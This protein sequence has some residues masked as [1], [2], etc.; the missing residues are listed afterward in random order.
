[1]SM[2]ILEKLLAVLPTRDE[3]IT[4]ADRYFCEAHQQAYQQAREGL[5]N[6]LKQWEDLQ[7]GQS[8]AL[9]DASNAGDTGMSYVYVKGVGAED[10]RN[11]FERLPAQFIERLVGYFNSTYHVEIDD[12]PVKEFLLPKMRNRYES[13]AEEQE[14]YHMKMQALSLRY[15][16]VLEQIFLQLGS[17]TFAERALD[18]LKEKCHAAAWNSNKGEAEFLLRND[19]LQLTS[20]ACSCDNWFHPPRWELPNATK[21]ILRGIAHFETGVFGQYPESMSDVFGYHTQYNL[22]VFFDCKKVQQLKLFKNGRVDIK[23]ASKEYGEQFV[24]EYLGTAC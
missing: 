10:F 1:M 15:E 22:H 11:A 9:H 8:E 18:E 16:D 19:T 2:E 4:D 12:V 21:A 23:F 13:T 17:R 7:A 6:L 24:S 20:Y 14:E 3:R 5:R